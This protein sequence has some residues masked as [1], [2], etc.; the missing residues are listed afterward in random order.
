MPARGFEPRRSR[1]HALG[2]N[3]AGAAVRTF[4]LTKPEKPGEWGVTEDA[5]VEWMSF[6]APQ[7]TPAA[8]SKKRSFRPGTL[9]K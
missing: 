6:I 4:A 9:R 1:E 7:T 2:R 8:S 5:G 3:T